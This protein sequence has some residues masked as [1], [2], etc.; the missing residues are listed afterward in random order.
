M[1]LDDGMLCPTAALAGVL[2]RSCTVTEARVPFGR[3]VRI[4][5]LL[6]G[7]MDFEDAYDMLLTDQRTMVPED[8]DLRKLQQASGHE[9]GY[10]RPAP[11]MSMDILA[12]P[13]LASAVVSQRIAGSLRECRTAAARRTRAHTAQQATRSNGLIPS[14]AYSTSSTRCRCR[15]GD[16]YLSGRVRRECGRVLLVCVH[17]ATARW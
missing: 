4:D 2:P 6:S 12:R 3:V 7:L 9:H 14:R 1:Q 10:P 8:D 15:F 17:R 5:G 13:G 11:G 16:L